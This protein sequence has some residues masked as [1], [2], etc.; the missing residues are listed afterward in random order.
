[1]E[2]DLLPT[3]FLFPAALTY[4]FFFFFFFFFFSAVGLLPDEGAGLRQQLRW[5][6]EGSQ[7]LPSLAGGGLLINSSSSFLPQGCDA[8]DARDTCGPPAA[9]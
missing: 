4:F 1:M 7:V 8:V 3:S 5:V 9:S 6:G 2:P